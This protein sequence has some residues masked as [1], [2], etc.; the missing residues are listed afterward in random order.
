MGLAG[1][2]GGR[3]LMYGL[4]YGHSEPFCNCVTSCV[5]LF[6][7]WGGGEKGDWRSEDGDEETW[8]KSVVNRLL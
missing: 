5:C 2:P 8:G 7:L 4:L 6:M 3:R 1:W